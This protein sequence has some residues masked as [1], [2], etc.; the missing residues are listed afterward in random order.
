MKYIH[1]LFLYQTKKRCLFGGPIHSVLCLKWSYRSLYFANH[2]QM[3]GLGKLITLTD[4]CDCSVVSCRLLGRLHTKN[5]SNSHSPSL[6]LVLSTHL[7]AVPAAP[8]NPGSLVPFWSPL[9][10][11]THGYKCKEVQKYNIYRH[12]P[13]EVR[14]L[15]MSQGLG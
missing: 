10:G 7:L 5:S 12:W 14:M 11:E 13:Q 4:T 9:P 2:N 6:P 3:F 15:I 1:T 8:V